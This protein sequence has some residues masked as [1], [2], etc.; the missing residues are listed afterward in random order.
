M[1]RI[2]SKISIVSFF[3]QQ[4]LIYPDQ[5]ETLCMFYNPNVILTALI[6]GLLFL[7]GKPLARRVT[8]P[9]TLSFCVTLLSLACLP[10]LLMLA[11]YAHL[12]GEP[13][14][15]VE[16]RSAPY[17]EVFTALCAPLCGYLCAQRIFSSAGRWRWRMLI[18]ALGALL[19]FAPFL[20]PILLPVSLATHWADHWQD[21]VCL[22]SGYATC[23][24]AALA[25]LFAHYGCQR[26]ERE[27]ARASYSS[28]S[29]TEL[30]YMMRYAR[31]QGFQVSCRHT[32]DILDAPVPAILGTRVSVFGH[33]I[34]LLAASPG[35]VTIG[36]PLLGRA[37]MPVAE[38]RQRYVFGGC[39]LTIGR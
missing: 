12:F 29:G 9:V 13:L 23:G 19:V 32:T 6:A 37:T 35:R 38:F 25:T 2:N 16:W 5:V 30:W 24:P 1:V 39:V 33:F 20:K 28:A 22:Q 21:G 3:T 8:R 10:S 17:T 11:Y 34:V 7:L 4:S 26:T 18:I 14:W 27:I 15:Y 36:D 31:E